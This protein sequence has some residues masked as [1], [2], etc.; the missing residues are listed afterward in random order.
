MKFLVDAQLPKRL[1]NY[2]NSQ[3]YYSIHTL[4]LPRKNL[5]T[6]DEI[7]TISMIEQL[8]VITKDTDFYN[9]FFQKAE[10]FKL[11]FL[12][13]GN[14]TTNDILQIFEKNLTNI[15]LQLQENDVIELSRERM[16]TI[17]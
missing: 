14:I 12:T 4:D 5:T 3:G 16:I 6:D 7:I 9:S 15:M 1:S 17:I 11:I 8:V 2:L 10:P 13:V